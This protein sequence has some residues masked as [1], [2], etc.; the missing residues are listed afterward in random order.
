[1]T[2]TNFFPFAAPGT[3]E[4]AEACAAFQLA[5]PVDPAGAFT[6][7][8]VDDVV[9]AV[10]TARREGRPLR[11]N[12]TG[13]AMGRTAPLTD[14]LLVRPLIDAPVHV[15][16]HART[17]RVPAGPASAAVCSRAPRRRPANTTEYPSF[18]RATAVA[19]PIPDPAPVT[20]AI[21]PLGVI[22]RLPLS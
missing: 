21:F 11:V 15:D 20:T 22:L 13:H 3:A 4:Y 2:N 9:R 14:S 16:P 17:A 7:R 12:T 5:A 19:L 1:M 8:S 18:K 6:A 10:I